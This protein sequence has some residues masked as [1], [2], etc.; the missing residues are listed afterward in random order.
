MSH[1]NDA[2]SELR[3]STFE[4]TKI[5]NKIKFLI[6]ILIILLTSCEKKEDTTIQKFISEKHIDGKVIETKFL[7][8]ITSNDSVDYYQMEYLKLRTDDLYAPVVT[9]LEEAVKFCRRR[10]EFEK[11][12]GVLN[13]KYNS[14]IILFEA[15]KKEKDKY[16]SMNNKILGGIYETTVKIN[17]ESFPR[18]M[19][20]LLSP[21]LDNVLQITK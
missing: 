2:Y 10:I 21:N 16:S 8:N 18:K 11:K 9:N 4:Q 1:W 19:N 12:A 7:K 5:M 14:D 13:S 17:G 15:I 6:L 3:S 20:V